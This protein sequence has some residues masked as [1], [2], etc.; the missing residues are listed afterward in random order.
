MKLKLFEA[1]R[2]MRE[3]IIRL[4]ELKDTLIFISG[5]ST[6]Q[7]QIKDYN[8]GTN[9]DFVEVDCILDYEWVQN[10]VCF[11]IFIEQSF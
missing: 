6:Q 11:M 2:K 9:A 8:F 1:T 10:K 3:H 4:S 7:G 5:I